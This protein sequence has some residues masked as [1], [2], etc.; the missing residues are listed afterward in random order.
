MVIKLLKNV[1]FG[2]GLEFRESTCI[3]NAKNA[4]LV[5]AGM[6]FNVTVGTF[7]LQKAIES[8]NP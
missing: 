5:R 1:G 4:S 3:L 6:V 7:D 8:F 2:M